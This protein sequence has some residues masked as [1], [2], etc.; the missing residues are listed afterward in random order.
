MWMKTEGVA[1]VCGQLTAPVAQVT[2]C[3]MLG[4]TRQDKERRGRNL[5][6][7]LFRQLTGGTDTRDLSQTDLRS[8]PRGFRLRNMN[9][10][11]SLY[12]VL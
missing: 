3:R 10:R 9:A 6:L 5:I 11:Y 1:M 2:Q 7:V 12:S 4:M 8:E